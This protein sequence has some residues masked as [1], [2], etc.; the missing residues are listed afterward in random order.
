VL[1]GIIAFAQR[2]STYVIAEGIE[3]EAMLAGIEDAGMSMRPGETA[4][5]GAQGYLFARPQEHIEPLESNIIDLQ[6]RRV[7]PRR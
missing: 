4:V 1:S 7:E 5:Q 3:T 2:T 6:Q